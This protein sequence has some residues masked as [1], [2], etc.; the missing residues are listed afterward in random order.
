MGGNDRKV[1][2]AETD[3][4]TGERKLRG[5]NAKMVGGKS[6]EEQIKGVPSIQSSDYVRP[7]V[8]ALAIR[9]PMQKAL[10]K[11]GSVFSHSGFPTFPSNRPPFRS[12]S[13]HAFAPMISPP[14][15][16]FQSFPQMAFFKK[17]KFGGKLG[18]AA[19]LGMGFAAFFLGGKGSK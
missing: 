18:M 4:K 13:T 19:G 8:T 14:V 1:A 3:P 5:A 16:H 12:F 11:Y 9:P 10:I 17:M 2:I 7:P 15:M 6:F